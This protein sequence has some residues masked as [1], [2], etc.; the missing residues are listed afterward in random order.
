M[1][2]KTWLI[3]GLATAGVVAL[4]LL[5]A[6]GGLYNVAASKPHLD[7]TRWA[8]HQAM[9]NSVAFHARGIVPPPDLD[10]PSRVERGVGHYSIGCAPCH[11]GPDQ[12]QNLVVQHMQPAPPTLDEAADH[13]SARELFWI[14]KHGVKYTGMPAWPANNRD[15][16]VWAVVAYLRQM[17]ASPPPAESPSLRMSATPESCNGCHGPAGGG[18]PHGATPR[19]AGQNEA[20]LARTLRDYAQGKRQSGIM[21]PVAHALSEAEIDR[22]AAHYAVL[23]PPPAIAPAT[24]V[25]AGTRLGERLVRAG[26]PES[27]V[28]ACGACHEDGQ[29]RA[30]DPRYPRLAGQPAPYLTQ[31]LRLWRAG[32]RGGG[33]GPVMTAVARKLTDEQIQAL[34]D[35]YE[36]LPR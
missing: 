32:T 9:R 26:A 27:R 12:A 23:T 30:V 3:A 25:A 29:G 16:E 2:A 20:Y 1:R 15:D 5:G 21:A 35:Y 4:A 17:P 28:P 14:V 34:A 24:S 22:L 10:E 7:V 11:G 13:W 8:L 36:S 6:W 31:Q 19:L 18:G 33:F